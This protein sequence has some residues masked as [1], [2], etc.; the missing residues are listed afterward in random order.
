MVKCDK[1]TLATLLCEAGKIAGPKGGARI[2]GR[3]ADPFSVTVTG[4]N[5]DNDPAVVQIVG[6]SKVPSR[7]VTE[8]AVYV[9]NPGQLAKVVRKFPGDVVELREGSPAGRC[10][11][12]GRPTP[13][14]IAIT[15]GGVRVEWP[16]PD[17]DLYP[18]P[19]TDGTVD[20]MGARPAV[21][22]GANDLHTV[23]E[24]LA[25]AAAGP[26]RAHLNGVALW[27]RLAKGCAAAT[28]GHRMHVARLPIPAGDVDLACGGMPPE[29]VLPLPAVQAIVKATKRGKDCPERV[30]F[31]VSINGARVIVEAGALRLSVPTIKDTFPP[32]EQVIPSDRTAF[33]DVGHNGERRPLCDLLRYARARQGLRLTI[34][35]AGLQQEADQ[36]KD[37]GGDELGFHTDLQWQPRPSYPEGY[38]AT[39][40]ETAQWNTWVDPAY[41]RE[42]LLLDAPHSVVATGHDREEMLA[43]LHGESRRTLDGV[44]WGRDLL[45][46]LDADPGDGPVPLVGFALVMPMRP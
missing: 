23:L 5:D 12:D 25:L 15:C 13:A 34:L 29:C 28:D 38:L 10:A 24:W 1:K 20:A 41:L 36:P 31:H 30:G 22:Y 42:A 26:D 45:T 46:D 6:R 7:E 40:K 27:L 17:G 8:A 33:A 37:E 44:R 35:G 19:I 2:A 3:A 39:G 14:T 18:Q 11:E 16:T 32:V 21:Y 43:V 4:I 9:A